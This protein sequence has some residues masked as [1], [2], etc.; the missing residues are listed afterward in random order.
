[1]KP[2]QL[3]GK[4]FGDWKVLHYTKPGKDRKY[5]W[6]CRCVCGTER[7]VSSTN[8]KHGGS[9]GCGCTKVG[10]RIRP[11]ESLYNIFLKESRHPVAL[12]YSQFVDFT[13]INECH[14]CEAP[15]EW[16]EFH[17]TKNGSK[18]NLDRKDNTQGYTKENCV[19]CCT[20][21]NY[22]KHGHFTYEQMLQIG[23]LIRSW[24]DKEENV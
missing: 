2:L 15:V 4:T 12:T 14:Y 24:K 10:N 23:L 6:L 21:C 8:L 11:F 16:A 13:K 18:Y 17:T 20:R 9:L 5:L 1:M 3:E 7:E 19:V 22:A